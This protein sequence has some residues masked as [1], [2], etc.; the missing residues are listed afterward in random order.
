MQPISSV[1]CSLIAMILVVIIIH[2]ADLLSRD[3]AQHAL[4]RTMEKYVSNLR[5][6]LCCNS[7]GKIIPPVQSRCLLVRIPS[8]PIDQ[9]RAIRSR[10]ITGNL[11]RV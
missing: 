2:E 9:V 11:F 3:D 6:I 8:P 5:I 10:S 4:R 7:T 1:Q